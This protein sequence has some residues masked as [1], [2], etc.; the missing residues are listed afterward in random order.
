M[1]KLRLSPVFR[2]A[3][4]TSKF[5]V[6]TGNPNLT[7]GDYWIDN[8]KITTVAHYEAEILMSADYQTYGGAIED[9]QFASE[10]YRYG[11][12]GK[13]KD[14]EG[15]GG[16]GSTYDYGFRIYNPQIGK[17]LSVDPLAPQY[18]W[19]TP[20]QY[21][22]NKPIWAIDR[23]GLEE[24]NS[25]ANDNCADDEQC[26]DGN[27]QISTDGS[28]CGVHSGTST[29]GVQTNWNPIYKLNGT[30]NVLIYIYEKSDHFDKDGNALPV[31]QPDK[32]AID[33]LSGK[34]DYIMAESVEE[35]SKIL[36][37]SSA[38]GGKQDIKNFVLRSHGFMNGKGNEIGTNSNTSEGGWIDYSDPASSTTIAAKSIR[39]MLSNDA[40]IV[41]TSCSV[42]RMGGDHVATL[43]AINQTSFWLAGSSRTLY[44]N[45]VRTASKYWSNN[46]CIP[47]FDRTMVDK[48]KEAGGDYWKGF[49]QYTW[50]STKNC[51]LRSPT[52]RDILLNST[53]GNIDVS[54]LKKAD[55]TI[56]KTSY[57]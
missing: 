10:S 4:T 18:P 46:A 34:W 24:D 38:Y 33:R 51:R 28:V 37:A 36:E 50:D 43:T 7:T 44:M 11:F 21:A 2:A 32:A 6:Y 9:R 16:G 8:L 31:V 13:E 19:Y 49:I 48:Y 45:E 14:D 23:D 22:G 29:V 35:A 20:Y 1:E 26:S 57:D 27:N 52:S 56:I 40:K 39:S 5:Y 41:F 54:D 55:G 3:G 30:G 17:F 12:N 15:M 47:R 25:L 42:M 53:T